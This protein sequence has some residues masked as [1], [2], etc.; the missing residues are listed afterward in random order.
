[1]LGK[2]DFIKTAKY[3]LVFVALLALILMLL[4]ILFFI[5]IGFTLI[6]DPE[7][8]ETRGI[9]I[10]M[11]TAI[12]LLA[13]PIIWGICRT[14]SYLNAP[15]G[16]IFLKP[17]ANAHYIL[18]NHSIPNKIIYPIHIIVLLILFSPFLIINIKFHNVNVNLFL[19]TISFFAYMIT[20]LILYYQIMKRFKILLRKHFK[21]HAALWT[22]EDGVA[23]ERIGI[24]PW[25]NIVNFTRMSLRGNHFILVHGSN[26]PE[27]FKRYKFPFTE[28]IVIGLGRAIEEPHTILKALRAEHARYGQAQPLR[29]ADAAQRAPAITAE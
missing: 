13:L 22:N 20:L 4:G 2:Q 26:F 9:S 14:I 25:H 7:H 3:V 24:L 10:G 18:Y 29:A 8:A 12:A 1:M 15:E 19:S 11:V 17:N 28:S 21:D 27:N 5:L 6:A 23:F 16:N